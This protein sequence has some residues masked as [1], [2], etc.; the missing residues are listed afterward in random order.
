MRNAE[1]RSE[2]RT[3]EE[4]GPDYFI[5]ELD[6]LYHTLPPE[7]Y[8]R[9]VELFIDRARQSLVGVAD[10]E[11]RSRLRER[12]RAAVEFALDLACGLRA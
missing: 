11:E 12:Y 7:S 6:H 10:P 5:Q 2:R 4:A 9:A 1:A 8:F 3:A